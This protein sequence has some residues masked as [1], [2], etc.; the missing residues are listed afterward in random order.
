MIFPSSPNLHIA[1]KLKLLG[2][3]VFRFFSFVTTKP[4]VGHSGSPE[5][6]QDGK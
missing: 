1:L 6:F 4:P 5:R 2:S 3:T